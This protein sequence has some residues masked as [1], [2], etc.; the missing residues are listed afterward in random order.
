MSIK[1]RTLKEFAK[2]STDGFS[3]PYRVAPNWS[4]L[5]QGSAQRATLDC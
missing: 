3:N 5:S 1:K 2:Q 4:L